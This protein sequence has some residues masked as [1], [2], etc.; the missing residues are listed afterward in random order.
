MLVRRGE[1]VDPVL[2]VSGW[3]GVDL[4]EHREDVAPE[5]QFGLSV[6]GLPAG[7]RCP[8]VGVVM[9]SILCWLGFW[10]CVKASWRRTRPCFEETSCK[11]MVLGGV[12]GAEP[13][14]VVVPRREEL[15]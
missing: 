2:I 11:E 15:R 8:L 4:V 3:Q 7:G 9:R 14:P 12:N 6:G 5:S 1:G 10:Q 13:G